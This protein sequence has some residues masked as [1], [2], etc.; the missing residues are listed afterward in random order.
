MAAFSSLPTLG[1]EG[2]QTM[3]TKKRFYI[4]QE[5]VNKEMH[6]SFV[7]LRDRTQSPPE[8]PLWIDTAD[9]TD[10]DELRY[11]KELCDLL[12]KGWEAT[13]AETRPNITVTHVEP[14][15]PRVVVK[16]R[17]PGLGVFR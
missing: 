8:E 16:H 10:T 7:Y 3:S 14:P 11:L 15:Q 4:D 5:R 9:R 12:N 6:H 17:R 13:Q 2:R 1:A